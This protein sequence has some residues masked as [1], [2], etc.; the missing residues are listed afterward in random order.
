MTSRFRTLSAALLALAMTAAV[1]IAADDNKVI[2]P[3]SK[4]SA[5]ASA[6]AA[7]NGSLGNMSLI[8]GL[9]LAA[10]GGWFVWRGRMSAPLSRDKALLAISETRS[11]G[12][13]QYLVVASYENKKFLLGVCPGRI[14]LLAPL[15]DAAAAPAEKPRS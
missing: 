4:D 7:G 3:A 13:R 9:V 2:F 14:D 15:H 10:V 11:L 12:N 5:S 6:G 1:A 8:V